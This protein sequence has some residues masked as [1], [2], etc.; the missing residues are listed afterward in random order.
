MQI[1]ILPV[2]MA[3]SFNTVSAACFAIFLCMEQE[4]VKSKN[5]KVKIRVFFTELHFMIL[6]L[7]GQ[8]NTLS[9]P[10]FFLLTVMH[11]GLPNL[12]SQFRFLLSV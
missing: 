11:S 3:E 1:P 2:A 6:I 7:N 9:H 5:E 4:E 8:F 12:N 10:K